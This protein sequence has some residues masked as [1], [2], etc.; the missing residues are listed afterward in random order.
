MIESLFVGA[1]IA[2]I[3]GPIFFE[4]VRRTLTKGLNEGVTLVIG[5]FT[6]NFILLLLIFF[7]A[8]QF[9]TDHTAKIL[10]FVLGS[11]IL[12]WVSIGAFRLRLDDVEESYKDNSV[13]EKRSSYLAGLLIALT[14][15][16]V[17]ALWI[18]L[19]SSYLND[20]Q[21]RSWAFV[22]I[23]LIA[24]GFLCFFVPVAFV[25]HK[26][27]HKIPPHRVVLLSRIFGCVLVVYA[28]ILLYQA[29]GLK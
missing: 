8:S 16:I 28:L 27:R 13:N 11:C 9:L 18:S 24:L 29:I 19:S 14:S 4:L 6:G 12:L 23:L 25:V 1:S 7:G 21:S 20:L 17:I 2:A 3:P 15:P 10:F 22:N 26:T 5:E